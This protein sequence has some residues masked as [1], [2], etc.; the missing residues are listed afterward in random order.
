M[1]VLRVLAD[2]VEHLADF[3]IAIADVD[4]LDVVA[5]QLVEGAHVLDRVGDRQRPRLVDVADFFQ[6][7]D[8]FLMA[9]VL[10]LDAKLFEHPFGAVHVLLHRSR[11]A[12]G[13]GGLLGR[14][15]GHVE[16]LQKSEGLF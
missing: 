13:L 5:H 9:F 15:S 16:Y 12:F 14:L 3:E 8:Q 2:R 6:Q 11:R 10:A 4:V 7:A 1:S